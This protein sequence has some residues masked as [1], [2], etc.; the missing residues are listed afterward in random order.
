[1]SWRLNPRETG[2]L[3]IDVQER[4]MPAIREPEKLVKKVTTAV[5]V[6]RLFGLRVF[7][8]EQVPDKLGHTVEAVRA[9]LGDE[10][11]MVR[12]KAVISAAPSFEPGELP[13]T[14][15]AV[16]LE[17]HVCVR[18]TV[19]DLRARGHAVRVLADAVS[20]RAELDHRLALD[21][22][23]DAAGARIT[24]LETVAWE[25]LERAEGQTFKTLLALV[26]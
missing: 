2:L 12:T 20:S 5:A 26:K 25:F 1:M 21:E 13:E 22:M 16:G 18:Q 23:S 24:T 4:L 19:F 15:L 3:V 9:A 8:T 14:V 17:T 11:R 6:A 10:A 7:V